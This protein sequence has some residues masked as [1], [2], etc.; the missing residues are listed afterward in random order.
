MCDPE[1]VKKKMDSIGT[2]WKRLTEKYDKNKKR[3][4][5]DDLD[6]QVMFPPSKHDPKPA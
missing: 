2:K 1:E 4:E 3:K 5:Q 6:T